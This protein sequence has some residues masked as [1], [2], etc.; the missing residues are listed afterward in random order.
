MAL[1]SRCS[2]GGALSDAPRPY[3]QT[4][5]GH[6]VKLVYF[7]HDPPNFGDEINRI[8]WPSLL[9]EGFLDGGEDELLFGAGSI[10][11]AAP[12]PARAETRGG[13]GLWRVFRAARPAR[14][15]LEHPVAARAADGREAGRRPGPRDLRRAILLRAIPLPEP[16]PSTGIAFMPHFESA[17]RGDWAEVCAAGRDHLSRSARRYRRA[18]RGDPRRGG[19]AGRG[20]AWR[21]HRRRVAHALGAALPI[22]PSH[23]MK[24]TDWAASLDLTLT[25]TD[26]PPSNLREAY[27]RATGLDGQGRTLRAAG[28][29]GCGP[30]A[31]CAP[32]P[33]CRAPVA[34]AGGNGRAASERGSA[35]RGGHGAVPRT[36]GRP[37]CGRGR[38]AAVT[39]P[40]GADPGGRC[41]EQHARNRTGIRNG[42]SGS[43]ATG[44]RRNDPTGGGRTSGARAGTGT[45]RRGGNCARAAR[46]I[47]ARVRQL[48]CRFSFSENRSWLANFSSVAAEFQSWAEK[49]RFTPVPQVTLQRHEI[50]IRAPA[51]RK[52]QPEHPVL[53]RAAQLGRTA[54]TAR[55][56]PRPPRWRCG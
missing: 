39:P 17:T 51:K 46:E 27:V 5:G 14:R 29:G 36:A 15:E 34:A 12:G 6:I 13:F 53:A 8:L 25:R 20:D 35:D 40:E 11:Q 30:P 1:R 38:V 23:R 47:Q 52:F 7:Q 44:D 32:A 48:L 54:G 18:P 2:P 4:D 24:W 42:R 33:P 45:H 28:R 43:K 56:R 41:V 31:E 10:L 16:A 21:H 9:P 3:P 19:G 49:N 37:S 50:A 22:H 55:D 26:M